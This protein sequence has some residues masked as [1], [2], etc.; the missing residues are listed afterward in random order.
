MVVW[1]FKC[2]KGVWWI[3]CLV[4]VNPASSLTPA[5]LY[6]ALLEQSLQ[7]LF[8]VCFRVRAS[9]L[10]LPNEKWKKIIL[11]C[12]WDNA[13][14][15]IWGEYPPR[16]TY[17]RQATEIIGSSCPWLWGALLRISCFSTP[18]QLESGW[19]LPLIPTVLDLVRA[20]FLTLTTPGLLNDHELPWI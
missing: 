15:R 10:G 4:C 11:S 13:L 1:K 5:A 16:I 2:G 9:Q 12:R 17:C 19:Q 7:L 6:S 8:P 18:G 3:F 20:D 14:L